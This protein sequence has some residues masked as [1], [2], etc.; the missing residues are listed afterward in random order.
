MRFVWPFGSDLRGTLC[1][2]E[3]NIRVR[4][5]TNV[6]DFIGRGS[7]F[8]TAS[9]GCRRSKRRS[10]FGASSRRLPRSASQTIRGASGKAR[11]ATAER[12]DRGPLA[13][14]GERPSCGGPAQIRR[15]EGPRP[16]LLQ[17]TDLRCLV[18]NARTE[19]R[20]ELLLPCVERLP[21]DPKP[22]RNLRNGV[23]PLGDLRDCTALELI[24]EIAG[25]H[26]GL[27]A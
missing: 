24:T 1:N 26:H 7:G 15:C 5:S 13:R 10:T 21:A 8:R 22:L 25:P 17:P 4:G 14:P 11:A 23:T 12:G 19:R 18:L 16:F 27:L 3:R 2:K 20:R 6:T 9:A